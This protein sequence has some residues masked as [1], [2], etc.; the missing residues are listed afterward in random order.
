MCGRY[1]IIAK[2]EEIEK[3][4]NV[5][6]PGDYTPRY[7]AAPTQILP[8]IT[9]QRPEGLSF[10]R[11]GLVPPWSKDISIG[12]K[13]INARSETISEKPS[14]KNAFKSRRCLVLS[15]GY[16]EWKKTSK[17]T[18]IPYR[19][20]LESGKLFSFAGLWEVYESEANNF[21]HTFTIVTT[22]SIEATSQIHERMPVI[23]N[24]ETEK[25]WLDNKIS[26]SEHLKIL[27]PFNSEKI[28]FYTISNLVNSVQNDNENL[29]VPTPA[30]DQS[31]NLSLFD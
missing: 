9:N 12:S 3:R 20:Q 18:K 17:K 15:D 28:K 24:P 16:Y 10:F 8:V 23:L 4:F 27:Q 19:I 1:T 2:A 14:F 5:E 6:V 29:I 26:P 25:I 7:N 22:N 11:W 13:L 30:M 21:L 31:G